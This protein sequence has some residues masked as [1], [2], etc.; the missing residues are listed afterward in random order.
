[1]LF[2]YAGTNPGELQVTKARHR[3][4]RATLTSMQGQTVF[5]SAAD[6]GSGWVQVSDGEFAGYVPAWCIRAL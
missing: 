6:D 5:V 4:A 2:D 1:M 3:L